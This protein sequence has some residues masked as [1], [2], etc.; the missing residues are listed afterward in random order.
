MA[1]DGGVFTYGD[2]VFHGSVPALGIHVTDIVGMTV[3]TATGGYWLVGSDG[4]VYA[5]DSPFD[6]SVAGLGQHLTNI[7]GIGATADGG[8]YY[9][10]SSTGEVYAFGDAKYQGGANTLPSIN[11]PIVGL[12]VDSG[13]GGYL[14]GRFRWRSAFSVLRSKAQQAAG[15]SPCRLSEWQ[16]LLL[17][18]AITW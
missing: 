6:G 4:G 13:T 1:R 3:D 14:G 10:V 7:V 15:T 8:G 16:Q 11:A 5:F 2:G 9:L 17:V 18:R 12:S